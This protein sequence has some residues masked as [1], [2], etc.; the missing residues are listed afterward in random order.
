MKKNFEMN[1][2]EGKIFGKLVVYALPLVLTNVL[3]LLFNAADVAVLGIF[4]SD[5]AVAAVGATGA[6]INLIIGLFVGLSVGANVLVARFS[7]EQNVDSAHKTVGTS[8]IVSLITGVI[9]AFIGYFF[10]ETFL[11]WTKCDPDVLDMA[12]KYLKIYFIG[13]PIMMLYNFCASILRAVGDTMRPLIFLIIGG[14][15]NIGLNIF[16]ILVLDKTVEGVAIA[17]VVSQGI[18]AVL[19]IIVLL[20]GKGYAKL[21]MKK[22]KI[23][24]PELKEMIRIGLPAGLQG[25]V[26]SI[27]N[28]LIQSTINTFS[29]TYMT[30]NTVASQ[31]DGFIYNAM[32]AVALSC[33]AFVSQNYGA[34]KFDRI[35]TVVRQSVLLVTVIGLVIGGGVILFSAQLC[36]LIT[37]DPEIIRIA[38]NRLYILASTYFTC[39]I[40]DVLSNFMRGLGKSTTAMIVSLSGSCLFR[41]IWLKTV[42]L[43]NPTI[44]MVYIVYPISW[45]LTIGVYMIMYFP[46]LNH[47]KKEVAKAEAEIGNNET[48]KTE[49]EN[50]EIENRELEEADAVAEAEKC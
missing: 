16:F 43:L 46:T 3:Q 18:S 48:E 50:K 6:L 32:N 11:E 28:V 17:T 47:A 14:V 34:K 9:L 29:K 24:M 12:T 5:D 1:M 20:K 39:G 23:Y 4:V 22:F 45:V 49:L 27:S 7:G 38:Q 13:M 35:R 30:A 19:S 37:D 44:E 40:M 33:L 36:G 25:C 42:Y 10:A 2:C 41:I 15:V 31:F 8:V 26:F 21:D